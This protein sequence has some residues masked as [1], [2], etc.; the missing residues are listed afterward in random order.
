MKA[1]GSGDS[2]GKHPFL[3]QTITLNGIGYT[4][5]GV[6]ASPPAI[7]SQGEIWPPLIIDRS[8]ENRL[9]HL[10]L[11]VGRMKPGVTLRQ[12][13]ADMNLVARRTGQEFPEVRYWGIHLQT[14]YDYVVAKELRTALLVLQG[15]VAL[16]LL[17]A[18]AFTGIAIGLVAAWLAGFVLSALLYDVQARDLATFVGVT[19]ALSLVAIT[20]CIA[21][22]LRASKSDPIVA[23]RQE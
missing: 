11:V 15:T 4:V 6:V 19:L 21:P 8:K 16:V 3:G 17:I 20:A 23:P 10:I 18:V 9:R 22:A 12:A 7:L 2:E 5:V 1:F 14:I 13:Q